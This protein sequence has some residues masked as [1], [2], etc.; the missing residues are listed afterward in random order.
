MS[1]S[2]KHPNGLTG[3]H[4]RHFGF[5]GPRFDKRYATRWGHS[6]ND[7][8]SNFQA[9]APSRISYSTL[10]RSNSSI[11]LTQKPGEAAGVLPLT[12]VVGSGAFVFMMR[13]LIGIGGVAGTTALMG[14]GLACAS[15]QSQTTATVPS[16]QSP[17]VPERQTAARGK[18]SFEVISIKQSKPETPPNEKLESGR[19]TAN[20]MLLGYID[21]AWNL[22]PS[23]EQMDSMLARLPKWV[24]A[25]SFEIRA[26]AEGNP[27][28][29]Q[30]R[31]MVQ[32]LLAERFRLEVHFETA[33]VPVLALVLDK[34]GKTGPKLRPHSEGPPCDVHLP[35]QIQNSVGKS[36]DAFPPVCEQL[37]ATD[38]ANHAV[39]TG[40]RNM[41]IGQIATFVSSLGRLDRP[42][43]DQTGLSGHFDFTLEFTPQPKGPPSPDKDVQPDSQ[44]T[45]LQEALQ[46][47][48]GLKLKA[49]TAPLDTLVID[50]VERP[51]EN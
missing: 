48:L 30:M 27:T 17:S 16:V 44:G 36:V 1:V 3:N 20:A 42:V 15:A 40:A 9:E 32:S 24:S 5:A 10:R 41:T 28:K 18:V 31:L 22:M 39:L 50:H 29:E 14:L 47:Q 43:V 37:V 34:P 51:S 13:L 19:F 46:D 4:G 33:E 25:D 45:T 21:F 49:A 38:K 35:S 11:L 8:T 2:A 12:R 23:R 26:V 6:L 7:P